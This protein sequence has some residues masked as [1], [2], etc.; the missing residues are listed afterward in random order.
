MDRVVDVV[1]DVDQVE[2]LRTSLVTYP[3]IGRR[4]PGKAFDVVNLGTGERFPAACGVYR[5]SRCGPIKAYGY[6]QLAAASRPERF[7]TLTLAGDRWPDVRAHMRVF[8]EAVRRLHYE[9]QAFWAVEENPLHTGHHIHALQHGGYVP[10]AVLQD[11]WGAIVHIE[12]ISAVLEQQGQ[13]SRY[14]IK[15]TGAANYVTKGS[16]SDLGAHLARNGGRTAHW[17][18]GYMRLANDDPVAAYALRAALG[19]SP[20][21]GPWLMVGQDQTAEECDRLLS[22]HRE[23]SERLARPRIAA[24][25]G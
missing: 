15:G 17:S 2:D 11:C 5:C 18:R 6:G 22:A 16:S 20:T 23:F 9:W 8:V 12:A 14:V 7:V 19:R 25:E 1:A 4:C 10:Q 21:P 13:V 3:K 24:A